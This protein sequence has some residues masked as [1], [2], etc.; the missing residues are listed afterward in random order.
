MGKG[1]AFAFQ[2][3]GQEINPTE[4]EDPHEAALLQD[5]VESVVDKTELIQCS[6]HGEPPRFLC[7]GDNIDELSLEVFGCC[8]ALVEEVKKRLNET[9]Q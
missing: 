1:V 3:G 9:P 5:I 8:D 7:S 6:E 2:I 4:V